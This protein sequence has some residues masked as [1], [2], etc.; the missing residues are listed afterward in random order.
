M[1]ISVIMKGFF[2]FILMILINWISWTNVASAL[3]APNTTLN[4]LGTAIGVFTLLLNFVYILHLAM[5]I[6]KLREDER[7]D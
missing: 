3:T 2:V 7:T 5:K 4:Y 6:G 1:N